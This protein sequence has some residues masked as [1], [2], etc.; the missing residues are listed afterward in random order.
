M[1]CALFLYAECSFRECFRKSLLNVFVEFQS[2]GVYQATK[3]LVHTMQQDNVQHL[4]VGEMLLKA[5]ASRF[6][7]AVVG[8]NVVDCPEQGGIRIVPFAHA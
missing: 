2:P 1:C 7:Y 6:A 8:G 5:S 3:R 4:L